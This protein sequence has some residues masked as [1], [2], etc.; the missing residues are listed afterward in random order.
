MKATL[1][2]HATG[3]GAVVGLL[4]A[5]SFTSPVQAAPRELKI[6]IWPD[7]LDP[8]VVQDFEKQH[9]AEL[10]QFYFASDDNRNEIVQENGA[11]GYD[12]VLIDGP[13]ITYY[14]KRGWLAP[15]DD[16]TIPHRSAVSAKWSALYPDAPD[17]AV[18]YLWGTLGIAYRE[19]LIKGPITR[20]QDLFTPAPELHHK[21]AMLDSSRDLV[22][23]ALKALGYSLNSENATEL[24]EAEKLLVQQRPFVKEYSYVSLG[25]QS[26]LQTGEVVAA[27]VFNGDALTLNKVNEHIRYV[28]P[29]EGCSLWVDFLA[30]T[31]SSPNK[32][33]AAAF[34]DFINIPE[35]AAR[36]AQAL[37]FATPN[38][39]AEQQ[40][41]PEFI[42]NPQIYPP[43]AILDKSETYKIVSPRAMKKRQ[44]IFSHVAQ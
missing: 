1:H 29:Q 36:Q 13:T 26:A 9:N 18:P 25:A 40:L 34:I 39:A 10:K 38:T 28:V 21:I 8:T 41:P 20:W 24:K 44:E 30:I 22:G 4:V 35:V 15:L 6:L 7:Y 19:D 16:R 12:L 27:M 37:S 33:L 14:V 2:R 3:L 43:Q 42:H 31:A 17:Y 32:D 23:A 11:Q 5:L